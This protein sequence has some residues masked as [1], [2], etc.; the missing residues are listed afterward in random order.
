M[1]DFIIS[2]ERLREMVFSKYRK[3]RDN[4]WSD[5][6][7]RPLSEELTDAYRNGYIDG[8]AK[9]AIENESITE[10]RLIEARIKTM[11]CIHA[12]MRAKFTLA[13]KEIDAFFESLR[14][15]S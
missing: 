9:A 11:G 14:S 2:E 7:S 10:R 3:V 8:Q 4:I 12:K 13:V 15:E 1:T 6:R 5:V